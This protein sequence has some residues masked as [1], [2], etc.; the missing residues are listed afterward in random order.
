MYIEFNDEDLDTI[1][2]KVNQVF[3]I[4]AFQVAVKV[5]TD[6]EVIKSAV[7]EVMKNKAF[8]TF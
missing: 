7:L 8:S 2:E 4:H 5:E 6:E 3:G 1:L